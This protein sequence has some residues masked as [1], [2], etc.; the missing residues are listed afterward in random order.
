MNIWSLKSVWNVRE[1]FVSGG[2]V[3][4]CVGVTDWDCVLTFKTAL[5]PPWKYTDSFAIITALRKLQWTWNGL[6][7]LKWLTWSG[8]RLCEW[9]WCQP[10]SA[11]LWGIIWEP[12]SGI[13]GSAE[14]PLW[15]GH[16]GHLTSGVWV[17]SS[18]GIWW[19]SWS[20]KPKNLILI[21]FN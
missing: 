20:M 5:R 3:S 2:D 10:I 14:V 18:G 21:Y 1:H 17:S 9:K 19:N 16:P 7:V 6:C 13:D 4:C 11:L 15:P 8:T 12:P